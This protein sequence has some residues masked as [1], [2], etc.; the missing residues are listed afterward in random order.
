MTFC[1]VNFVPGKN[2]IKKKYSS[3]LLVTVASLFPVTPVLLRPNSVTP[4]WCTIFNLR[5]TPSHCHCWPTH[6]LAGFES[7]FFCSCQSN[8]LFPAHNTFFPLPLTSQPSPFSLPFNLPCLYSIETL[9]AMSLSLLP[10]LTL[11]LGPIS[12]SLHGMLRCWKTDTEASSY[13]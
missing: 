13:K 4:G 11:Q 3:T 1:C 2:F 10:T 5:I 12:L 6:F 8:H 7:C 9:Q